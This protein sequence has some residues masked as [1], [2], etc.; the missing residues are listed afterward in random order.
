MGQ[1]T[2]DNKSHDVTVTYSIMITD[3]FPCGYHRLWLGFFTSCTGTR[4]AGE[5][6]WDSPPPLFG[7]LST[8]CLPSSQIG[9]LVKTRKNL[10][11]TVM[12]A[13]D[14]NV[15]LQASN[16]QAA[17]TARSYS[18]V[19]RAFSGISQNVPS[20]CWISILHVLCCTARL[21]APPEA[22]ARTMMS[23]KRSTD[24]VDSTLVS[25]PG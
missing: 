19:F 13:T 12:H 18:H 17:S 15:Q 7:T 4:L 21:A 22:T 24:L 20:S 25:A 8:H 23:Y 6:S 10:V 1:W 16:V 5:L 9:S 14:M 2:S 3:R 11:S